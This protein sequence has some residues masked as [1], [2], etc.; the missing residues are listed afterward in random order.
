MLYAWLSLFGDLHRTVGSAATRH[1]QIHHRYVVFIVAF[2]GGES[3]YGVPLTSMTRRTLRAVHVFVRIL[4]FVVV[5][6]FEFHHSVNTR[7]A[8]HMFRIAVAAPMTGGTEHVHE[9][10]RA[11]GGHLILFPGNTAPFACGT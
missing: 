2:I 11:I 8:L 10:C 6:F 7:R 9:K 4:V 5:F 1:T 3:L